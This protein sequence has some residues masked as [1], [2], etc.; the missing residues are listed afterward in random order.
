MLKHKV[1]ITV[2]DDPVINSGQRTI[3]SR[4]LNWIFGVKTGVF[5]LSPGKSVETVEILE[6]QEGGTSNVARQKETTG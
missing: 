2:S 5:V 1:R 6:L 4:L 3:R